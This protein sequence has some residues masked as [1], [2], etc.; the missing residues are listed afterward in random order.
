MGRLPLQFVMLVFAG[1]VNR[2][3]QEVIEYLEEEN[4]V[5]R[6]Q[7][8]GKRLRFTDAQRRRLARRSHPIGRRGLTE[9]ATLVTPDT[10]LRWYRELVARKYDGSKRSGPGRPRASAEVQR[11]ILEMARDNPGWGYTRIQGALHNVG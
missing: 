10:L 11:L 2:H 6:E 4:C 1:W 3:Q 7:L 8:G 9:I 5:L